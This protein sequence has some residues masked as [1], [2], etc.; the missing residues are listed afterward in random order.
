MKINKKIALATV[1]LIL[2]AAGW[3][4]WNKYEEKDPS[5]RYKSATV[6]LGDITQSASANGTLNPVILVNVGTQVSGTVK[7]LMVD[8][9]DKVKAGQTLAVLDPE[10]LNAQIRQSKA[11]VESARSSLEL[12]LANEA[13]AVQLY[14]SEYISRQD[15]DAAIQASKAAKASLEMASASLQK[16]RTNLG[17]SIIKSPVSG[18]VIDRQIDIGQTVAASFQTPTLFKIAQDLTK[19]QIDSSF[20]EADIGKIKVG[21]KVQF[22]V[23]A[24]EN[25]RFEGVVKQVRLNAT[26]VSNVITYDVVIS[27]EN[28][29][30]IL[31]PSMTAYVN[32]II[33]QKSN[34]LLI[35]NAALRYRPK[36]FVPEKKRDA[37]SPEHKK[38]EQ[39]MKTIFVLRDGKPVA[40]KVKIG[41]TDNKLTEI[42]SNELK[43]GDQVVTDENIG[44]EGKSSGASHTRSF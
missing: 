28:P 7:K 5:Q 44:A 1:A 16:D 31:V 9:N 29:D 27:V 39:N 37:K 6:V 15:Y 13:R 41:I 22:T 2:A 38:G 43:A 40:L 14:K 35:P 10:M 8:F 33:A 21:Q 26:T 12:A 24:F 36:D 34:V 19:M 4:G 30:Y 18:V 3:F 23:D 11:G 42:L 20:A 17:Y 32:V 25:K